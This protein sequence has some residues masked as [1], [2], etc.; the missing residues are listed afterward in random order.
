MM[1]ITPIALV[2]NNIEDIHFTEWSDTI[3]E[4]KMQEQFDPHYLE[5]LQGASRIQVIFAFHRADKFS[6]SRNSKNVFAHRKAP[7]PNNLAVSIVKLVR[8]SDNCLVVKGLDAIN[9][10]PVF[11]LKPFNDSDLPLLN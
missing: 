10:S 1:T 6:F 11:D 4:I 7:R 9:G 8:V 3:S 5:P 2:R